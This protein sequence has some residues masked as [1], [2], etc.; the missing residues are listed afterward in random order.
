MGLI[1]NLETYACNGVSDTLLYLHAI[2]N[3]LNR[4]V[5][6]GVLIAAK[7]ITIIGLI[8]DLGR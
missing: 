1:T 8:T 7:I 4:L 3:L 5:I 2:H 6:Y